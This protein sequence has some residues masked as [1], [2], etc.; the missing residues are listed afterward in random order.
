MTIYAD[1]MILLIRDLPSPQKKLIRKL[2]E[3]I[4]KF[5]NVTEYRINLHKAMPFLYVNNDHS[6]RAGR[7][8][9]TAEVINAFHTR[10]SEAPEAP[11]LELT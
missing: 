9:S 3:T 6:C 10:G 11:E 5:N 8:L 1:D 4:N 2:L 7:K